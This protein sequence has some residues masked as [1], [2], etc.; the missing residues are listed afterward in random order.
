[1]KA[2]SRMSG[3]LLRATARVARTEAGARIILRAYRSDLGIDLLDDLPES[4]RGDVP[5]HVTPTT[6]RPPR[7]G[8]D[9][10]LGPIDGP[11][12]PTTSARL[13]GAYAAGTATPRAIV[14]RAIAEAR[15]LA[16]M[17]PSIGPILAYTE[18]EAI[19]EA[20]AATARY[21]AKTPRGPLDGVPCTVK[22][23][24]GVRGLPRQSG[25]SFQSAAPRDAD[26]T[27]V[28][29]LRAAGAIV[30]GSSPMTEHGLSP[31]GQNA[32]RTLPKNPHSPRHTAGGSSTGAGV[33]V[34]TGLVPFA[35]GADGG[36]SIRIPASINGVFGIKPTWGRVSRAGDSSADTVSHL[37]PLA[38]SC[39]DLA[40]SLAIIAGHDP[41]DPETHRAPPLDAGSLARAL[42]RGV[43]GLRI[44][45]DEREW[46]D[47]AS[48]VQTAGR[49]ALRALERE[50][51][52]LV[53]LD[54]EM[55]RYA[56]A[57]GY[58]TIGLE[59]RAGIHWAWREDPNKMSDDLQIAMGVLGAVSAHDYLDAQRLRAGLRREVAK[60]FGGVDLLA[61]PAT[62]ET[63][64]AANAAEMVSGFADTRALHAMCRFNFLANLTGLP[65]SSCPV[66]L[67]A[68]R[69]P[70]GL[71]LVGDAWDEATVIA[72]T[73]HLE[74][75]GAA[76]VEPPQIRVALLG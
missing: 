72:A 19:A 27:V 71:Q 30:I 62:G 55:A 25:A 70:I 24:T 21:A 63:A 44:G 45:V 46:R 18:R 17:T 58:L 67:D 51:A 2:P 68:D 11:A 26:A 49:E 36:G 54:I 53:P 61:L 15:R 48:S 39:T 33:S 28:A 1:M 12:W 74:R 76:R 50:G 10:R 34:A 65:A 16:A 20:D 43:R 57:I 60:A 22:E 6:G 47:A 8:E 3:K 29:R 23:Q 64:P 69:L 42:G 52:V 32:Q 4:A 75:I 56:P 59:I 31:I 41:D 73:A 40:H 13:A 66:G 37:G 38:S 9:A 14:E 5:L 35:L 7:A